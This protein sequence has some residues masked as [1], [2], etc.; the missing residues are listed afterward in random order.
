[1]REI[2]QAGALLTEFPPGAPPSPG[3]FPSRNR[4][5]SGLALGVVVVEAAERSGSLITAR[6]ALEQGREVFAVPGVARSTR[7]KGTHRL[8]K[9]GAKLVEGVE[10]ILEE[11]RPLSAR[12]NPFSPPL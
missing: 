12:P 11:I 10:D 5:I 2:A 1:M 9:Q 3:N 7:S 8:L 6:L 4:I